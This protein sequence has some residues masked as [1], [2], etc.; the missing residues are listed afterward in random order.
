MRINFNV[1]PSDDLSKLS[2]LSEIL[3][4]EY[5]KTHSYIIINTTTI[6]NS[7]LNVYI[8]DLLQIII[9][10]YNSVVQDKTNDFVR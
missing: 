3:N 4:K 1:L 6:N 5:R 10:W 2:S 8:N 7:K 9:A